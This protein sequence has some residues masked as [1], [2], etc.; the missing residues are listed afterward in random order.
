MAAFC[1]SS[2][3]GSHGGSGS[4]LALRQRIADH[5]AAMPELDRGEKQA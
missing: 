4:F 2:Q 5:A 3:S 1:V